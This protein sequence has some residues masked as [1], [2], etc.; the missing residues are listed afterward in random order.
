VISTGIVSYLPVIPFLLFT[1]RRLISYLHIFQQEE[2]DGTRFLRWLIRT[3]SIDKKLSAVILF[4][5]AADFATDH[6]GFWISLIAAA[7]FFVFFLLE[8]DPRK[9]G[10]K[11]LLLTARAKRILGVA[12]ALSFIAGVAVSVLH[13]PL[14]G[15]LVPIHLL[16]VTLVLANLSLVPVESNIQH[17]F[18][19]EAHDKLL[20][21]KPTIVG[22]TGSFGKTSVKH[23]VGHVLDMSAPTLATP[24]SINT[25]MGIA[26]VVRE[27]LDTRH[28]FFVCEM[29]AYGPGSIER[30]CRL[31]PPNIAVI[32]AIG[33]AHYER[34]KSLDVVARTKLEL[35]QAVVTNGGKAII[36][37][38]V[39]DFEPARNF[40]ALHRSQVV[41]VGS[42]A[43]ADLRVR[44]IRQTV[45]GLETDLEWQDR[46]YTIKAPLYGE[47]HGMNLAL[48]FGTAAVV[49]ISVENIV[50]SLRTMP[51]IKHRLEVKREPNGSVLIDDAYNSNPIGFASGLA[52]LDLLRAGNGRRILVTPGMVELGAA[53]KKEHRKI[54]ALA[55]SHV[56]ILLPIVPERIAEMI[57]AY[58]MANPD[59]LV[60]PCE[61]F[62]SAQAWLTVNLQAGDTILLENDLPDLYEAKL[63]L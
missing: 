60:V 44:S 12:V 46:Q 1:V 49:G 13:A 30:L 4:V 25:P 35:A 40:Y 47:H 22:I 2:Y 42:S 59:G 11:K 21:L 3:R 43:E 20:K 51:Q 29:G 58:Q 55:A 63:S 10:K 6:L 36:A 53:H 62:A 34:F 56:D 48:A 8:G 14:W 32:T 61:N 38:Q 26:R 37:E 5:G 33:Y 50:L 17:R 52:V 45:A 31:A 28:R 41:I 15:W 39:L 57:S 23:M 24:G 9:S 16:P 54:G 7:A 18:W 19:R 27:Q